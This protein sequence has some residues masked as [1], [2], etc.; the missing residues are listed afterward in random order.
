M[1]TLTY[2]SE[3]CAGPTLG[4]R[5]HLERSHRVPVTR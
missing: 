2:P 5:R 4:H 1:P 3:P